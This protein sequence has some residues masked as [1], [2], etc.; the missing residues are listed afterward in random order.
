MTIN[1]LTELL[2]LIMSTHP[3]LEMTIPELCKTST[4]Q[5][6]FCSLI[7]GELVLQKV[8][9]N[10]LTCYRWSYLSFWR[11]GLA[12]GSSVL[13]E[14]KIQNWWYSLHPA[15][16]RMGIR[17]GQVVKYWSNDEPYLYSSFSHISKP[18]GLTNTPP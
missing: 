11:L 5:K 2:F 4:I 7:L 9:A 17:P 18:S 8:L 15:P 16:T 10:E 1:T 14:P 3:S 6:N 13:N 12:Q